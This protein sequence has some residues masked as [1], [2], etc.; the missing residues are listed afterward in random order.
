MALTLDFIKEQFDVIN[1]KHFDGKLLTPRFEITHVKSYLG[2]YHWRYS[3]DERIFWDS[4]IRIS[5]MFDRTDADI[6]NTIAHEM[7][8]LYIRQNKLRDTRPHHGRI[9]KSVAHRLNVEGGFHIATTD[10]VAGCGLRDKTSTNEY[11]VV[12]F[13]SPRKCKYFEFVINQKSLKYY[14]DKIEM[15]PN[16]FKNAIFFKSTDDKKYAHYPKCHKAIRGF[17]ITENEYLNNSKN[18]LY[19]FATLSAA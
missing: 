17:S 19:R 6:T 9:F 10:S 2:Q 14:L 3:Y 5:D 12:N 7:I 15:Y 8:H 13:Y 16:Y 4:V 18:T 1:N 11:I